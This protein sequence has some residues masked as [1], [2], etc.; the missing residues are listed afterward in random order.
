LQQPADDEDD[1]TDAGEGEH[2]PQVELVADIAGHGDG[3]ATATVS[4]SARIAACASACC[5]S[6][7]E[8][9]DLYLEGA[10]TREAM[11]SR[12]HHGPRAILNAVERLAGE[13]ESVCARLQQ[14][15][16]IAGGTVARLPGTPRRAVPPR[17]V[18]VGADAL[19]DQLR[20]GLSASARTSGEAPSVAELAEKIKALKAAHSI[21]ASPKR[22]GAQ[23]AS[24]E[25]AITTRVRSR[26]EA[27]ARDRK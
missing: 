13:Y 20:V 12:E 4:R 21:E 9:P 1:D 8:R 18:P 14:D 22:I 24:A 26:M 19:R 5:C 11:L 2:L 6:R 15:L 7:K 27:I 10:G 17:S 23:Y 16:T 3:R 25:E